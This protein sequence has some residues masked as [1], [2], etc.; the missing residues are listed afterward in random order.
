[1]KYVLRFST[2]GSGHNSPFA[3]TVGSIHGACV[4]WRPVGDLFKVTQDRAGRLTLAL[5]LAALSP[6]AL[7]Q[8]GGAAAAALKI[9]MTPTVPAGSA[10]PAAQAQSGALIASPTGTTVQGSPGPAT[11]AATVQPG[12]PAG[13]VVV[14]RGDTL[15]R[16]IRRTLGD[17][18]FSADFLR[19]TFVE[20]NPHAFRAGGNPHLIS[21][22]STLRVPT[23]VQLQQ[24][25]QAY[26]PT[27]PVQSA[28]GHEN[29]SHAT[30][31]EARKRWVRYP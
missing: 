15:D 19:K 24:R 26:F 18:P 30:D 17:T 8:D 29:A 6:L 21:A 11:A 28:T 3:A 27:L 2:S 14:Q 9:L 5:L 13:M 22:G 20:L 1:M 4:P 23:A 10:A 7:A 31:A 12:L 25:M 16:I